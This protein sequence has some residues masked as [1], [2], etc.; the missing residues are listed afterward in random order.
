M[1]CRAYSLFLL[2]PLAAYNP[3]MPQTQTHSDFF[4]RTFSSL[5][6]RD[7]RLLWTGNLVFDKTHSAWWLGLSGFVAGI[8]MLLFA[9]VGGVL[10][11][12]MNR[13]RL[14]FSVQLVSLVIALIYSLLLTADRLELWHILTLSFIF[15]ASNAINVPVRQAAVTTLVPRAD[16]INAISMHSVALNTMR[17]VGPSLAGLLIAYVG[18]VACYW[19]QTG[20]YVLA[21][22]NVLQMKLPPQ[23]SANR[24]VS[25]LRNLTDGLRYLF[26]EKTLFGI[27]LLVSMP[28]IFAFP[29]QMMLPLFAQQILQVGP[30]G[31]GLLSAGVGIGAL[32]TA[33]LLASAGNVQGKGQK[34]A[35]FITLYGLS[36]ALFSLSPWFPASLLALA[37]AGATWAVSSAL[38]QTLLQTQSK[39]EYVGRLMSVYALTWGLQPLGNLLI[40]NGAEFIGAP[41]ALGLGGLASAIGTLIVLWRLPQIRKLS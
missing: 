30:T 22:V 17:I 13:W 20:L 26:S 41:Y 33:L 31:L 35:V 37:G 27:M 32:V 36:V 29:Y 39:P 38:C 21:L 14:M 11:D 5:R 18:I 23:T 24:S 25:P 2:F 1:A 7:F 40:G 28:T 3:L 6:H 4:A 9:L 12:R 10:A 16:L 19:I 15:G 34:V 8:P